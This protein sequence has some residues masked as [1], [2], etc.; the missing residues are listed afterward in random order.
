MLKN[1]N[2]FGVAQRSDALSAT[3]SLVSYGTTPGELPSVQRN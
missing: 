1:P 3:E 2:L